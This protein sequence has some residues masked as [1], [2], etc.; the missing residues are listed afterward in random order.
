MEKYSSEQELFGAAEDL[1]RLFE[2]GNEPDAAELV[3]QGLM[4]V[5]GLTDGWAILLEK[6]I[7]VRQLTRENTDTEDVRSLDRIYDTLRT[8]VYR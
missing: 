5:N 7:L 4:C 2:D 3:R 6:I 8:I 1:I